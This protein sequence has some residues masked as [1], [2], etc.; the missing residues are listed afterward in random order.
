M[1]CEKTPLVIKNE[2]IKKY[3]FSKREREKLERHLGE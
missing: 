3:T 2:N 1:N